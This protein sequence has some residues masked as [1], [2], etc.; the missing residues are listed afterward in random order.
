MFGPQKVVGLFQLVI[1]YTIDQNRFLE[2]MKVV[3]MGT[4]RLVLPSKMYVNIF[5]RRRQFMLEPV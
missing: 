4:K 5:F 1:R 3:W 2:E